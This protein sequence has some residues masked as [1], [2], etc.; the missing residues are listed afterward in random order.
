MDKSGA[1]AVSNDDHVLRSGK[2]PPNPNYGDGMRIGFRCG[3]V[4]AVFLEPSC[5]CICRIGL[6]ISFITAQSIP[7]PCE[8]TF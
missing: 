8:L 4:E 1:G 6:F 3:V 2:H 5:G 7:Q